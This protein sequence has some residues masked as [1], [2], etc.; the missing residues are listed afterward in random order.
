MANTDYASQLTEIYVK[1]GNIQATLSKLALLSRVNTMQV[2]LQAQLNA[3]VTR[4][5][6]CEQMLAEMQLTVSN[7]ITEMRTL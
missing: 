1:L 3:L 6:T 4:M 7:I 2:S 5:A